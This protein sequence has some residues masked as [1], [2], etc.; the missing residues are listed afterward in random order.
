VLAKKYPIK[1]N[2]RKLG[3]IWIQNQNYDFFEKTWRKLGQKRYFNLFLLCE[4]VA[5]FNRWAWD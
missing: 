5:I 2:W 3:P 4:K 1:Q